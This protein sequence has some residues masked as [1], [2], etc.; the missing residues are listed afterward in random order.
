VVP[1]WTLEVVSSTEYQKDY[2][3]IPEKCD[4]LGEQE[5]FVYDPFVSEH[6]KT[7]RQTWQVFRRNHAGRLKKIAKIDKKAVRSEVLDCWL[8][9]HPEQKTIRLAL[10]AF[11]NHL[12]PT[13]A[14]AQE[15]AK[16]IERAA[17]EQEP[18]AKEQALANV[19]RTLQMLKTSLK[20]LAKARGKALSGEEQQRL[21]QEQDPNALQA[22]MLSL[23]Q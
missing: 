3:T 18:T 19:E 14:E 9:A 12:F 2:E 6:P 1:S 21:D 4:E 7:A 23:V 16:E 8:T 22:W 17:K 5:L 20:E 13:E 15:Q 11:G 10:D